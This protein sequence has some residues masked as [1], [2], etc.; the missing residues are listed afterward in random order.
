MQF[1]V[2]IPTF[3]RAALVCEAVDSVLAQSE[4]P[5][6]IIVVD[7]GSTDG[8][9]QQLKKFGDAVKVIYQENSGISSARN[10]GI[11]HARC[12]WLAFLD[13]DDLWKRKKLAAQK[14]AILEFPNYKI[15]YTD[16]EWHK[17]GEWFNA[18]KV[19]QKFN[20][21]IYNYSLHRCFVSASSIILHRSIFEQHGLFDEALTA[22]EDYD[23]WLRLS[24]KEPFL[25]LPDKLIVKR[26]GPWE[27][28]SHQHSLD[29]F[30]IIALTKMLNSSQLDEEKDRATRVVLLQKCRI[31]AVGAEKHGRPEEAVWA[32][33]IE[34]KYC[35][36][37]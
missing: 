17:N 28:L 26:D 30:R 23:L 16:E 31:Y 8:T 5:Q 22:C 9:Q 15:C 2:I 34:K 4:P 14:E 11:K 35:I 36:E 7:D 3:N 20:G 29:R 13:S 32:R 25:F 19:H 21:W 10:T 6:E 33:A 24:A 37:V 27:Q 12:E 1:S 18:K